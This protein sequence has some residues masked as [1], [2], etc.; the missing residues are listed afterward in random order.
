VQR[1]VLRDEIAFTDEVVLLDGDW[2]EVV[3]D[4][5]Q[6][7]FQALAALGTGGVVHHVRRDE[8]VERGVVTRLLPSEHLLNDFLRT[9]LA[10]D[11][12]LHRSSEQ[13]RRRGRALARRARSTMRAYEA[14]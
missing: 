5:L 7:A 11:A 13:V 1:E 2:P 9:S 6:D 8:I 12:S 4:G 14:D 3:V 10:H